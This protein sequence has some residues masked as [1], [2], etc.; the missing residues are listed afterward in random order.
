MNDRVFLGIDLGTSALKLLLLHENGSAET[1]RESYGEGGHPVECWTRSLIR[2]LQSAG[3][4]SNVCAAALSSQVGTYIIS[5]EKNDDLKADVIEWNSPAGAEELEELLR[6]FPEETFIKET[7]MPHPK[8]ASYPLPRLKWIGRQAGAVGRICQPKEILVE[9]L[10]GEFVSDIWSWRGLVHPGTGRYSDLLLNWS[11]ISPSRLPPIRLPQQMAGRVCRAA[12]DATGL[13]E[14]TPVYTGLNDFFAALKGMG[15]SRSGQAFD[16][17]GSSEHLGVILP[18][19]AAA[20]S[21]ITGPAPG[22]YVHYGVSASAGAAYRFGQIF[23]KESE[24][25]KGCGPSA[26]PESFLKRGERA[27]VFLPYL[28]GE[29]APVFDVCARG[30][31]FGLSD[32]QTEEDLYYAVLEGLAFSTYDIY[33]H[34]GKPELSFVSVSGGLARD[35]EL[36][37]LKAELFQAEFRRARVEEASA[38]GAALT[39][40]EGFTGEKS[41]SD[42]R[43]FSSPVFLPSTGRDHII[44][45]RLMKRFELYRAVYRSLKEHFPEYRDMRELT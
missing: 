25:V 36:N 14:G 34:L 6:S 20:S 30:A 17:T 11:G 32:D 23:H 15:I 21:M 3:D 5:D 18:D 10:T 26:D 24:S 39:A 35:P 45:R 9:Y 16:I 13:K 41:V 28:H 42:N 4:L 43:T 19:P 1:I 33:D 31:F 22:G 12:A 2:A 7:G 37:M 44:Y 27:P 8:L 40:R 29:R 38:M